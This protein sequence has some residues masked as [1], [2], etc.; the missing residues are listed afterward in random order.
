M[1]HSIIF[2]MGDYSQ[3]ELVLKGAEVNLRGRALVFDGKQT[4]A[5]MPLVGHRVSIVLSCSTIL[6]SC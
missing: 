1:G 2:A 6:T 3:G 4:H 5:P